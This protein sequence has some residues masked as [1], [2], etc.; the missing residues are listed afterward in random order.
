[1][2]TTLIYR[3]AAAPGEGTSGCLRFRW[4]LQLCLPE[5][6]VAWPPN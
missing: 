5:A 6:S 3:E 2:F 4:F 1:M